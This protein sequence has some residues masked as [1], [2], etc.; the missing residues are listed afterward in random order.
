MRTTVGRRLFQIRSYTPIPF[1]VIG[2]LFAQPT[3][4]SLAGGFLSVIS[5][6]GIRLWAASLLGEKMRSTTEPVVEHLI[7]DGPFS[8]VRNPAYLGN[9]MIYGG[10]GLMSMAFFPWLVLLSIGWFSFQYIQIVRYEEQILLMRFGQE[11]ENYRKAVNRFL[12]RFSKDRRLPGKRRKPD[13][14]WALISERRSIQAEVIVA[15]ILVMI[16]VVGQLT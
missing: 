12:P 10:V 15:V 16:F 11:Y 7:I 8:F 14:Q 13:F 5:G 6:E 4:W 3:P 2:T 1:L 9:I